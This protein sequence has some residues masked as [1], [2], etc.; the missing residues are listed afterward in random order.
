MQQ[1]GGEWDIIEA[2]ESLHGELY[3]EKEKGVLRL[4]LFKLANDDNPFANLRLP[5]EIPII[6][7]ILTTGAKVVLYRCSVRPHKTVLLQHS[8]IVIDAQCAFWGIQVASK[9]E[10]IFQK[11]SAD[12]GNIIT[13]SKQCYYEGSYGDGEGASYTLKWTRKP[14][15]TVP[16]PDGELTIHAS[17]GT[18]TS[19]YTT[20][21]FELGQIVF[22]SISFEQKMPVEHFMH[23]FDALR[24]LISLAIQ[25][26]APII[27]L[28]YSHSSRTMR[29]GIISPADVTINRPQYEIDEGYAFKYLFSLPDLLADNGKCMG[30]W[31]EKYEQMKPIIDLYSPAH[32][33]N[34][35]TREMFFLNLT[36][37]LETFHSRFI[38]NKKRGYLL[39]VDEII[40][41]VYGTIDKT[42][43]V[44]T[45][46]QKKYISEAQKKSRHIILE[47]RLADL[48]ID[49]WNFVF[50]LG[51]YSLQDFVR[52]VVDTRNYYT[53]YSE[54]K[55][56]KAFGFQELLTANSALFN[57]L[58]YH[59]LKQM[60]FSQE[61]VEDRIRNC[62]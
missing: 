36:Q 42:S 16:I 13:W 26:D 5:K 4:L 24:R 11:M 54:D 53:H 62:Q 40:Q 59:I 43:T 46:A 1:F 15:I 10:L 51:D 57:I 25:Q 7:G 21:K 34:D 27:Q 52:K 12:F 35:I 33:N 3:I 22:F 60:G 31:F 20:N 32:S 2:N 49:E 58:R 39:R 8:S 23:F 48:I 6:N 30:L 17:Q 14:D 61:F 50:E 18:H 37:A 41:R 19:L 47:S 44:Y 9:D 29:N 38:C 56:D 55:K 45:E 28:Q